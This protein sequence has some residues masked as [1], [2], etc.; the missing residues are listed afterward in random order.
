MA[1]SWSLR[2]T[3]NLRKE[4]VHTPVPSMPALSCQMEPLMYLWGSFINKH[5]SAD[6]AIKGPL[7]GFRALA[8]Q[9][10]LLVG[11]ACS[12]TC[13]HTSAGPQF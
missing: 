7:F 4:C 13:P 3:S 8:F 10:M 12:F 11:H 6:Y 9:D 5:N 1:T 2:M